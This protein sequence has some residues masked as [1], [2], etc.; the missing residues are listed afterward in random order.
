MYAYAAKIWRC[1]LAAAILVLAARARESVVVRVACL[2]DSI[3]RGDASHEGLVRGAPRKA[4]RGNFPL[5]LGAAL[6]KGFEV[7]NFGHGGATATRGNAL[8]YE[9]LR[10]Y[11]AARKFAPNVALWMLGT[12]DSKDWNATRYVRDFSRA[13]ARLSAE[14]AVAHVVLSP[15]PVLDRR[16]GI[17]PAVVTGLVPEAARAVAAASGAA[18][19]DLGRRFAERSGCTTAFDEDV[20]RSHFVEDGIHTSERGAAL[21]AALAK[22]A[23]DGVLREW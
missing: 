13:V 14:G 7:R 5:A 18:F 15:P 11:A 22:E 20:C 21:I 4:G 8:S 19:F 17:V 12:N 3:T 23:L 10:E 1:L 6:G 16:F 2:G 9:K